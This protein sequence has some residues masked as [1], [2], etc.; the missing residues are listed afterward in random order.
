VNDTFGVVP[1]ID[2]GA[3]STE[4]Y[5]GSDT[6]V[7]VGVGIGLRYYTILGPIRFDFAVPLDPESGDG[8]FAIY[9]GLGQVF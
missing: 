4:L 6:K 2:A 1:F 3:V 5:P 7:K 8:D 9:A